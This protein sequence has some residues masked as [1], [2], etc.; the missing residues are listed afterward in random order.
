MRTWGGTKAGQVHPEQSRKLAERAKAI[1][2]EYH[3]SLRIDPLVAHLKK[4]PFKNIDLLSR[5]SAPLT[6]VNLAIK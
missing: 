4:N 1:A 6:A 2:R 3:T 5:L